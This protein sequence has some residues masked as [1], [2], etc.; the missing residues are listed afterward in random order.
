MVMQRN[1]THDFISVEMGSEYL[2]KQ[3]CI[4]R[5]SCKLMTKEETQDEKVQQFRGPLRNA[6]WMLQKT[7]E[8]IDVVLGV[9]TP[10][11][12]DKKEPTV[13]SGENIKIKE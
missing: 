5:E 8:Q 6:K 12:V 1:F 2:L 3:I 7:I 13:V 9:L 11:S 4:L 10:E